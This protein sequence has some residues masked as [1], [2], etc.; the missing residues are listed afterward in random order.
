MLHVTMTRSMPLCHWSGALIL[1][2]RD[3][4]N[5]P[6]VR[7]GLTGFHSG[8]SK[9]N[10]I[11]WLAA[12]PHEFAW[13]LEDDTFSSLKEIP[14]SGNADLVGMALPRQV[15]GWVERHCTIC[16][17]TNVIKVAW[18]ALRVSRRLA[19]RMVEFL[20][21]HPHHHGH[22]EVFV[23]TFCSLFPWCRMD[24]GLHHPFFGDI[25][26]AG[27]GA[28]KRYL[29]PRGLDPNL[30]HHPVNCSARPRAIHG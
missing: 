30:V 1:S 20:H 4:P 25:R 7:R 2:N 12:S 28:H 3:Q 15:G 8:A 16:N 10:F 22:H 9:A 18:P 27:G 6:F 13:H 29:H 24:V 11:T 23:G 19:S 21:R 26:M 17:H 14:Y 5:D